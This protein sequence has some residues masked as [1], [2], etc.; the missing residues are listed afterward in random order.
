MASDSSGTAAAG[1]SIDDD[2][3]FH[4]LTGDGAAVVT[5][6][7]SLYSPQSVRKAAH[8]LTGLCYVH[9]QRSGVPDL[10]LAEP[11]GSATRT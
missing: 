7:T 8:R 11:V 9:L 4:R 3:G 6:D 1:M 5:V 10:D 2:T